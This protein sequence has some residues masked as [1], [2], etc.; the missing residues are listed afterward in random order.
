MRSLSVAA[1]LASAVACTSGNAGAPSH[2]AATSD[3]GHE[4]STRHDASGPHDAGRE[5]AAR[6]DASFEGG[7]AGSPPL[8]G[9][10]CDPMVP[11]ECGYPFP[12]SVWTTPD[13]TMP[14]GVHVAF[15]PTTL[16]VSSQSVRIT[17]EQYATRDGFSPGGTMLT[18]LPGATVTGLPNPD[19]IGISVMST[20]PTLIMEADTGAL[21]PHFSELDVSVT[22]VTQ[23]AFMIHPVVRL[24]DSTRYIVAIRNVVDMNGT[25]I[26]ANPVFAALRDNTPSSDGSVARRRALYADIMGKLKANGVDTSSLQLAWD[27]TTASQKNTTSWLLS[28]RDQALAVVGAAGPSYTITLVEDN[29]NQWIRRRLTGMMTV[30]L[31]LTSPNSPADLNFNDAGVPTQNGTAQ[32]QFLVHIPNSLVTSGKPGPII[33]NGHGLLGNETEGENGYLAQLCDREGYVAV[34]IELIGMANDD[35]GFV[36]QAVGSNPSLFERAVE[37]QHQGLVNELLAMRMM[38]GRMST[39]PETIFNGNPTIDPTQYFWRGDS[40]G[41]ILGATFMTISTDVT[42]GFLGEPGAPYA[43][44]LNRSGDFD[45]FLLLMRLAYHRALDVE[46]AIDLVDLLWDRTEP[47]GYLPYMQQNMLEGTPAHQ[48]LLAAALGDHQVTPLG[49]EFMARTLGAKNLLAANQEIY[50]LTDSVGGFSGAGFV[51]WSFGLPLA[52]ITDLPAT[53]GADPHDELPYITNS[54]DMADQF[55]RTGIVNQTCPDGGP[56]VAVCPDGGGNCTAQGPE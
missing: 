43:L 33:E 24:K 37:R 49:A 41:G 15:G 7:T 6:T 52:P 46:L 14:N 19:T 48:V 40:Q 34:A 5:A 42:R 21:V 23:Q 20:S 51:L 12:S 26:P 31:Y 4:A 27:F 1:V 39:E 50:G 10:D 54:Q 16:P 35:S 17:S 53:E 25:P 47:D 30:P 45:P 3:A 38:I 8:L 2:D 11:Q 9:V 56:C 28:V 18:Y 32:F 55:L 36:A 13:S 44:L 29:P 22:D